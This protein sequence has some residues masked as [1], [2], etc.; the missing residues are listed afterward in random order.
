MWE[1]KPIRHKEIAAIKEMLA[2]GKNQSE[3]ARTLGL[4]R[5]SVHRT[6]NKILS[7]KKLKYDGAMTNKE[8]LESL[9]Q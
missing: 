6:V 7:G 3:I 9:N 1:I 2:D 5:V 8:Y 4:E